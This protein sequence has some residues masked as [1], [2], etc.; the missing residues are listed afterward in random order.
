MLVHGR[1]LRIV[2]TQLPAMQNCPPLHA[3]PQPPQCDVLVSGSTHAPLQSVRPP[4]QTTMHAPLLHTCPPGQTV[5]QVPQLALSVRR[6]RH[7]PEQLVCPVA[8]T[9]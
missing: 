6:S 9:S 8:Q 2:V 4:V 3:R 5:P 1:L 7:T